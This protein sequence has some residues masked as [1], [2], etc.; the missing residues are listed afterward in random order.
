MVAG[1]AVAGTVGRTFEIEPKPVPGVGKVPNEKF[2]VPEVPKLGKLGAVVVAGVPN[3]NPLEV[4]VV[5]N[6]MIKFKLE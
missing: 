2:D 1:V 3:E 5:G 6:I 4:V